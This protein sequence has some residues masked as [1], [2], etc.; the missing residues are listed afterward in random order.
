MGDGAKVNATYIDIIE[1]FQTYTQP[2]IV[3]P[4]SEE[5][6]DLVVEGAPGDD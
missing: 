3:S 2:P 4:T 5:C 6:G 1:H